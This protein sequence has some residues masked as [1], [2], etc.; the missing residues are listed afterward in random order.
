[1]SPVTCFYLYLLYSPRPRV[2]SNVV[3]CKKKTFYL[4][5]AKLSPSFSFTWLGWV[6]V[7]CS[8][9]E[10]GWPKPDQNSF[11][12]ICYFVRKMIL[13][14]KLLHHS[15]IPIPHKKPTFSI[16]LTLQKKVLLLNRIYLLFSQSV[17]LTQYVVL[18][19][20]LSACLSNPVS[21]WRG[22]GDHTN[23]YL[24]WGVS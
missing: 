16:S 5:I 11:K 14:Q 10:P 3:M 2:V 13:L 7:I 9:N 19:I 21:F 22:F 6:S 24:C 18:F 20:C 15:N 1:M 17:S 8:K 23:I 12:N 4:F